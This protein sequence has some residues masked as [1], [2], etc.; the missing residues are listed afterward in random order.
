MKSSDLL[1][2]RPYIEIKGYLETI[3][4]HNLF[5]THIPLNVD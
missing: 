2:D 1:I 3:D 5:N 4:E